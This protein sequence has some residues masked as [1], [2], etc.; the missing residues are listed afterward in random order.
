MTLL[1]IGLSAMPALA[2]GTSGDTAYISNGFFTYT[3]TVPNSYGRL[4]VAY[5]KSQNS[6]D[7]KYKGPSA[8]DSVIVDTAWDM[9]QIYNLTQTSGAAGETV[10]FVHWIENIGNA[11]ARID[12]ETRFITDANLKDTDWGRERYTIFG[13]ADK[14]SAVDNGANRDTT[15]IQLPPGRSIQIIVQVSIPDTAVDGDSSHIMLAVTDNAVTLADGAQGDSWQAGTILASGE[16]SR[17]TMVD[18]VVVQV[19][20]PNVIVEKNVYEMTANRSRPGDTIVCDITFDNDGSDSA[21]GLQIMDAIPQWSYFQKNSAES[22]I[23]LGNSAQ[24]PTATADSEITV[25]YDTDAASINGRVEFLDTYGNH[26]D[27][28]RIVTAIRWTLTTYVR[29]GDDD[30]NGTVEFNDNNATADNGRVQY[31]VVIE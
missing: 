29:A 11:T 31:R 14:D 26:A 25:Q 23:F 2:V 7:S 10:S 17:D 22:G 19:K 1:L 3:D 20:G 28:N 30:A 12:F 6:A 13:D 16:D 15:Y 5:M 4:S 18:T 9:T 24:T 21:R 8:G 27:T